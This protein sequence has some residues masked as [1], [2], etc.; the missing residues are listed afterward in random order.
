MRRIDTTTPIPR[1]GHD[2]DCASHWFE[3]CDCVQGTVRECT[4]GFRDDLKAILATPGALKG[5]GALNM[6]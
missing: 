6:K 4:T 3:P 2:P 5:E 1:E